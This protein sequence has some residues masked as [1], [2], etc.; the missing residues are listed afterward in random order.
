MDGLIADAV[1]VGEGQ[2][3]L[4]ALLILSQSAKT[5]PASHLETALK[6]KLKAAANA[7]TGSA[8]RVKRAMILQEAPSFDKGEVT[9]KGSLNQRA[10]RANNAA[11][12]EELYQGQGDFSVA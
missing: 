12:I 9:E 8:S 1:I 11:L 10:L 3:E 4:G 6:D 5:M 7:A 2:A